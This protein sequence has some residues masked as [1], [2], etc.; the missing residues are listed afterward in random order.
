MLWRG[1][2]G[3]ELRSSFQFSV[4]NKEVT[5][6]SVR[7]VCVKRWE[8]NVET[9]RVHNSLKKSGC[10]VGRGSSFQDGPQRPLAPPP[11]ALASALP[12]SIRVAP[13]DQCNTA[14]VME[15]HFQVASVKDIVASF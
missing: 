12:H 3:E 6:D 14:E 15:C 11:L 13:W 8:Q 9:A 1:Q 4:Q 2:L 10:E 7:I 5:R